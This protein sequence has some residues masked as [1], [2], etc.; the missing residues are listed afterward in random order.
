MV[1]LLKHAIILCLAVR[2]SQI[3]SICCV[4]MQSVCVLSCRI[5]WAALSQ[6]RA[7]QLHLAKLCANPCPLH[8]LAGSGSNNAQKLKVQPELVARVYEDVVMP[9]T[10]EVEVLYLLK[11]LS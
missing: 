9:L 3:C 10:K 4:I 2:I 8:A 1:D 6:C 5:H 11:R 7:H